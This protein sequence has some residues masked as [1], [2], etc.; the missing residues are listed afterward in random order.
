MGQA[1]NIYIAL[2]P[3]PPLPHQRERARGEGT[4]RTQQNHTVRRVSLRSTHPTFELLEVPLSKYGEHTLNNPLSLD[5]R[6]MGRGCYFRIAELSPSPPP[7]SRKGRGTIKFLSKR[8][9]ILTPSGTTAWMHDS[10]DGGGRT[11]SGT[12]VE[13]VE[14][15]REHLPRGLG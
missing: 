15:S 3:T 9:S 2:S 11:A 14:Q 12:A 8:H 4:R 6:G 10:M 1:A 7:L 5:G 13:E